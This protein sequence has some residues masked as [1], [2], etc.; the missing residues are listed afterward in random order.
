L[1][2]TR[3]QQIR[4]LYEAALARPPAERASFIAQ[5]SGADDE[6]KRS[7]ERLISAQDATDAGARV[8]GGDGESG[9]LSPGT[10]IGQYRIGGV[11]GRGGM[12]VVYRATDT[13]LHRPVAIKFLSAGV[14]DADIR[15]RFEREAKTTSALNHPHIV[16]V[17]DVGEHEGMQYIVSELVDGGTLDDSSMGSRRRSWRQSVELLTGV[18]DAL[19]AAHAAGVMHRDVK[20]GNI[21]IGSNGYAKLADFGLAKL[22]DT[23]D[24]DLGD[25]RQRASHQTRAGLVV[26]TVAYMSPEQAAGQP[27]DARSDV[28]SFGVV[29]YELLAGRRP[30][31][32]ANELEV[33]KAIA[34]AAPMPL[35]DGVPDLLRMVVDKALEKDPGDR[36]Q[37][38]QDLV[39]DLKRIARRATSSTAAPTAAAASGRPYLPWLVAAGC[40]LALVLGVPAALFWRESP[41]A[42]PM[43]LE[44]SVPGYLYG[45]ALS[46]DG[47]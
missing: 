36:Y 11:L 30:F 37:T 1:T 10:P 34:H 8:A 21:L 18:A 27:L 43:E 15:R 38:M 19:A 42:P 24:Y 5:L 9:D 20:P 32:S 35:P 47:R 14:A 12:G 6:L 39:A 25:P 13:K 3:E 28:F 7:V 22:V 31:E 2:A 44:I 16:T 26:G 40:A 4:A 33:L 41:P 17:H 29:L 46:A 45:A 23:G